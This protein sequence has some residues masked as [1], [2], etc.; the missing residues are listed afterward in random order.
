MN[1]TASAAP[2]SYEYGVSR[3]QDLAVTTKPPATG[4]RAKAESIRIR[5]RSE[6]LRPTR[7][8]WR[9]LFNRFAIND[10]VFRYFS[11]QEVFERIAQ[12]DS[13]AEFRYCVEHGG[14]RD[15]RLLAVSRLSRPVIDPGEVVDLASRFECQEV[16]I[17]EGLVTTT[18][19]PRSADAPFQI[20]GDVFQ[21]RYV[22]E[23]PVDGFGSP[24][25]YLAMLRLVCSNG[26]IAYSPTFR[27]EISVGKDIAWSLERALESFDNADGYAALR[28]RMESAQTSPASLAECNALY[29]VLLRVENSGRFSRGD[30]LERFYGLT[31]RVHELYGMANL[32]S[33]PT[34]RQRVLPARCRVYDLLNF[35]TEIAT[36]HA[37]DPSARRLHG[38]VG[39]M[40]ADEYDLEGTAD[41]QGDFQDL[42]F[43]SHESGPRNSL[44]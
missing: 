41:E 5:G 29:R 19:A 23:T 4:G 10:S 3:I 24:R 20:G 34:K 14:Q 13:D 33:L 11:H 8:F 7:R 17:N 1:S 31:G 21:H 9:S 42:F 16:S 35:A 2:R 18:H 44:N 6:Q 25:I 30:V 43:G 12:Q 15:P 37:D 38:L 22:V 40:V 28:Q 32:D 26:A 27:S 39:T 36:H